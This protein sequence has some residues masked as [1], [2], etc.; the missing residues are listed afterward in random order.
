ML[1]ERRRATLGPHIARSLH[2][3]LASVRVDGDA[4]GGQ[5]ARFIIDAAQGKPIAERVVDVGFTIVDRH[6]SAR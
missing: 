2:P 4:I 6:S 5:A 3:A 1:L